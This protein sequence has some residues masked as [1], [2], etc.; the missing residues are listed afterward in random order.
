VVCSHFHALSA[1]LSRREPL[2]ILKPTCSWLQSWGNLSRALSYED[3]QMLL[4]QKAGSLNLG[5]FSTFVSLGRS[6][7]ATSG[8]DSKLYAYYTFA[9]YSENWL[10]WKCPV[11]PFR[12]VNIFYSKTIT[13]CD[14]NETAPSCKEGWVHRV[15]MEDYFRSCDFFPYSVVTYII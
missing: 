7:M 12:C 15:A 3:L 11:F 10:T 5:I 13:S 14:H 2:E 1:L 9:E 8:S 4:G 6:W